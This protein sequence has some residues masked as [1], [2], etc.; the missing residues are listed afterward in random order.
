MSTDHP[1]RDTDRFTL[2]NLFFSR[3]D[4]RGVIQAANSVFVHVSGHAWSALNGAPHKIVRHPDMPSGVFHLMWEEIAA[5][6]SIGSYVKNL[7]TDHTHYWVFAVVLPLEDGYLSMR[8]KPSSALFEKV[9]PLYAALRAEELSGRL[10]PEQSHAAL[11]D[12]LKELGFTSYASFMSIALA[13]ELE[14]RSDTLRR[15]F[16]PALQAMGGLSEA[17]KDM[18]IYGDKV[19]QI[20]HSTA[21]IPNNLSIQARSLEG[22]NGPIS[23]IS[24]NHQVMAHSLGNILTRFRNAVREGATHTGMARFNAG[25]R[26]LIQEVVDQFR[27]NAAVNGVDVSVEADRLSALRADCMQREHISVVKVME[28]ASVYRGMSTDMRRVMSGLEM[29]RVM[30]KIEQSKYASNVDGLNEIVERLHRAERQLSQVINDIE[31]SVFVIE[32]RTSRLM[33]GRAGYAGRAA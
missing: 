30:C 9:R 14:A 21:L 1:T 18:G 15:R 7:A 10:N 5:G 31:S 8:L 6:R 32:D 25:A 26:V 3:T 2:E 22:A 20:F 24:N 33:P 4:A 27:S 12:K 13:Q 11:L 19:D 23:V 17:V 16:D 28:A 29:S